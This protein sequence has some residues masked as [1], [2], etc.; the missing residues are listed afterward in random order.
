MHKYIKKADIT[1]KISYVIQDNFGSYKV[2]AVDGKLNVF[3]GK[4]DDN[5]DNDEIIYSLM[6]KIKNFDGFWIIC[7]N[8]GGESDDDESDDEAS[9]DEAS[10]DE[11][12]N[13]DYSYYDGLNILVKINDYEYIRI[14]NRVS[15]FTFTNK[16]KKIDSKINGNYFTFITLTDVND[17]EIKLNSATSGSC[18]IERC[19]IYEGRERIFNHVK[20]LV[21]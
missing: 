13:D 2:C 16:I 18:L 3:D 19:D 21:I 20:Y 4:Y 9:D 1:D 17:T 15:F 8:C 7:N 6:I 5:D 10:N 14:G 11:A 12:S